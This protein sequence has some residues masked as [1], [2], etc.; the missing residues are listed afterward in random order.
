M[1][2][3]LDEVLAAARAALAESL[4]LDGRSASLE[5]Q[6]LLAHALGRPRAWLLAHGRD[7]LHAQADRFE[8]LLARRLAGEPM[9]YILG[10]RE[11]YGLD[12]LVT[13]A[14]L[15]PRP[16]TELLVELALA[17]IPD[18]APWLVLDLGTGSGAVALAI[19]RHRPAT[20]VCA[21]ERAPDALA[22]ARDN[23]RRLGLNRVQFL[24]GAW[25][26][27]LE[28]GARFQLIVAN[29]PYVAQDDPHLAQGDVRFEP[30]DALVAGAD[31]LEALRDI[32]AGAPQH[33]LPGAWLLLEHGWDQG[34]ACRTLLTQAGFEAVA[35][36][37]DLAGQERVSGGR[38][39]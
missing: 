8:T 32:I 12:L 14:V 24:E 37:R 20:R 35:S 10:R 9:A 34:A 21:V 29:P 18:S 3:T 17:H 15:I 11:F 27:A 22:V 38:L 16:E 2:P 5:A 1:A 4:A 39:P 31:G 26:A 33:L 30:R 28:P 36:H 13:P 19:A 23:A 7:K 6:L 25:F